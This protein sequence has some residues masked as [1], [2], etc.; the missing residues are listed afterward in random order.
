MSK[1]IKLTQG[2]VAIVDDEDFEYLSHWKWH[3]IGEYAGR[4]SQRNVEGKRMAILMHRIILKPPDGMDTDHINHNKLDNRKCNLRICTR[5]QNVANG[6][7]RS[8]NK[9]G[10]KGVHWHKGVN[11]WIAE[12]CINGKNQHIGV[13]KNKDDAANA[14]TIKAKELFGEFAYSGE[15]NR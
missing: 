8:D 9:T 6:F 1:E 15:R 5:S 11:K 2:K 7:T 10:I 3:I 12:I 4:S 14:Y 13:Y